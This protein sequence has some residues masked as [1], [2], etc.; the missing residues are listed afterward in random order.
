MSA[1]R[2]FEEI[3]LFV[4]EPVSARRTWFVRT[5]A[6]EFA[7]RFKNI[8]EPRLHHSVMVG[9]SHDFRLDHSIIGVFLTRARSECVGW[10]HKHSPKERNI[11]QLDASC[12]LRRT[13]RQ[14]GLTIRLIPVPVADVARDALGPTRVAERVPASGHKKHLV[15]RTILFAYDTE[16][17]MLTEL[18]KIKDSPLS[19]TA[20]MAA[21][22]RNIPFATASTAVQNAETGTFA[23][24][25]HFFVSLRSAT[26]A[27][28]GGRE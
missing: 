17:L 22:C 27:C 14:L 1:T 23:L 13:R 3:A 5:L 24:R 11:H 4:F 18:A 26:V 12:R 19:S 25:T 7:D 20:A 9:T 15:I 21:I 10:L 28:N 16:S 8:V 2:P 6:P